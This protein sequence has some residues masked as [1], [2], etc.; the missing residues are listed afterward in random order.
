MSLFKYIPYGFPLVGWSGCGLV[1]FFAIYGNNSRVGIASQ[2]GIIAA[3]G[4]CG[5]QPGRPFV[6]NMGGFDVP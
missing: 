6:G 1:C 5:L 3:R 4:L 2:A